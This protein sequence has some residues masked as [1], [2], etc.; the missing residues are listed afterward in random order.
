MANFE[1]DTGDYFNED[2]L[3]SENFPVT[4]HIGNI[5]VQCSSEE[6]ADDILM[7]EAFYRQFFEEQGW[8]VSNPTVEQMLIVKSQPGWIYPPK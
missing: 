8:D 3:K 1:S 2:E 6:M 7:R 4:I 5:E